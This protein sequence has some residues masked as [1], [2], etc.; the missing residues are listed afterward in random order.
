MTRKLRSPVGTLIE[1]IGFE[2]VDL[3]SL[4]IGGRLQQ[5]GG[6]LAGIRLPFLE[7]FSLMKALVYEREHTA[8]KTSLSNR[9][10]SQN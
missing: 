10:R 2:C 5:L 6:P 8:S 7:R 3:G 9:R 1:E 4:A